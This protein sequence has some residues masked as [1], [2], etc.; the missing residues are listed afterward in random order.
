[1]SLEVVLGELTRARSLAFEAADSLEG[2]AYVPSTGSEATFGSPVLASAAQAFC[3]ELED[4][5]RGHA[6]RAEQTAEALGAA[7]ADYARADQEVETQVGA[8]AGGLGTVVPG[9]GW[10]ADS[11]YRQQGPSPQTRE[12][13]YHSAW[14]NAYAVTSRPR[15]RTR[16]TASRRPAPRPPRRYT[17]A[18]PSACVV[19]SRPSLTWRGCDEHEC[20]GSGGRPG[21]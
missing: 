19:T 1:M 13:I 16:P 10:G 21:S 2:V 7:A 4:V 15:A 8:L 20:V 6:A 14:P 18:W 17:S 9:I 12:E 5:V 11:P 3:L